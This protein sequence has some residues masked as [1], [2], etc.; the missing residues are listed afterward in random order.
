MDVGF[1]RCEDVYSFNRCRARSAVIYFEEGP[2][3]T[4]QT[5]GLQQD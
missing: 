3:V 5:L 1:T 4:I 2:D